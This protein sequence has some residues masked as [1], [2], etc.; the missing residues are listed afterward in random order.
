M[1][2]PEIPTKKADLSHHLMERLELGN[3]DADLL[4]ASFLESI[5]EPLG[6]GEGIEL[7]GFVSFRL[8]LMCCSSLI[9]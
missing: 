6:S 8:S 1:K 3:K 2:A 5:I 9:A 4:V 7:R